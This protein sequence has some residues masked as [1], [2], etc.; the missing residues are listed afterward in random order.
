MDV[1]CIRKYFQEFKISSN[2]NKKYIIQLRIPRLKKNDYYFKKLIKKSAQ[3]TCI[4]KEFNDLADEI[5]IE[6]GGVKK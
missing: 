2:I 6:R 3:L 1:K 5:G 4:G